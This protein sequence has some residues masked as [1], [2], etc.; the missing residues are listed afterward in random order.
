MGLGTTRADIEAAKAAILAE[1]PESLPEIICLAADM[2]TSYP[3]DPYSKADEAWGFPYG[4]DNTPR[5]D[6]TDCSGEVYGL[7]RVAD[8]LGQKLGLAHRLLWKDGGTWRRGTAASYRSVM[9]KVTDGQYRTFD[10]PV[11]ANSATTYHI[12]VI[13]RRVN[14]VWQTVEAR[15]GLQ[16]S[17]LPA[18]Q[19]R[20]GFAGVY[21]FPWLDLGDES[22][23]IPEL[24][25]GRIMV[26][27]MEGPDV[28]EMRTR[29]NAHLGALI[30][31]YDV[32]TPWTVE[33]VKV[34]Q[35]LR[36]LTID[37]EVGVATWAE[38]VKIPVFPYLA[39]GVNNKYAG[40]AVRHLKRFGF[41]KLF[42]DW[43]TSV[44]WLLSQEIKKWRES[45][46]LSPEAHLGAE[47]SWPRLLI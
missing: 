23:V 27:G 16:A 39:S 6:D 28:L 12:A 1:K 34:F 46:G 22:V 2:Q 40:L 42:S 26:N 32:F 35:W 7:G 13:T 47:E 3:R 4:N 8:E 33:M 45:V 15:S 24:P 11:F 44:S 18:L 29:L 38:L 37:G 21:R 41:A 5:L 19:A 10:C 31:P 14:G 20:S 43:R 17:T 36:G 9:V 25:G 30:S